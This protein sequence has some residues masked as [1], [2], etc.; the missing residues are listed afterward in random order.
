VDDETEAAIEQINL[1][2]DHI[3]NHIV[4]ISKTGTAGLRYVPM[5]RR[6]P[7]RSGVPQEV[8]DLVQAGDRMGAIRRYRELTGVSTQDAADAIDG[9]SRAT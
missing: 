4:N 3:E 7:D 1:R 2:L 8:L 5:G 9:L 6:S